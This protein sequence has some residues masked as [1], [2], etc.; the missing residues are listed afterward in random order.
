MYKIGEVR[1]Y[2]CAHSH[3]ITM[4]A[5]SELRPLT[6]LPC[7]AVSR[8]PISL[9]VIVLLQKQLLRISIHTL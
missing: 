5:P 8:Y 7:G 3:V 6:R 1:A 9:W 2:Y 4:L